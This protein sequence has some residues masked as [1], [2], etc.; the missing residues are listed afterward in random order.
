MKF[1]GEVAAVR[2]STNQRDIVLAM[3]FTPVNGESEV[4]EKSYPQHGGYAIRVIANERV[5]YADS[6][7]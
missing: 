1:G 3:G 2:H 4:Y 5:E 7:A 6:T